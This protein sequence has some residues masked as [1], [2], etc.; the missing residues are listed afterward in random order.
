LDW[1][2][3]DSVERDPEKYSGAPVLRGT[4]IP[5]EA[6]VANSDAGLSADQVAENY[7]TVPRETI[8]K[9]LTYAAAHRLQGVS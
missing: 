8:L 7:P 1:S 6:I 3:C 4:R 5:P 9:V 2:E